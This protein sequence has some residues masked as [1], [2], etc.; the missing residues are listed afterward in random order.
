[1]T[2]SRDR[3]TKIMNT[4]YDLTATNTTARRLDVLL[5]GSPIIKHAQFVIF[6]LVQ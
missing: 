1:M 4:Q 6:D 3:M 5:D 2:F